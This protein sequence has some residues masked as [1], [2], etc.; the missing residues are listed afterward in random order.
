VG[1]LTGADE[2]FAHAELIA[3]KMGDEV[4]S[5]RARVV[6]V[7]WGQDLRAGRDWDAVH[8]AETA[9]DALQ[10]FAPA[11][12]DEGMGLAWSAIAGASWS[13][14]RADLAADAWTKAADHF[15]RAGDRRNE[16]E[17]LEWLAA[18]PTL[19]PTH[20]T[21]AMAEV[22][23]VLDRVR[24]SFEAETGVRDTGAWLLVMRGELDEARDIMEL[25]RRTLLDLGS[26]EYWAFE[27]QSLGWLEL[28]S[29]NAERSAEIFEEA[30]RTLEEMGSPASYIIAA[31]LAQALYR[32]DRMDEAAAHA[33]FATGGD[34]SGVVM[35]KGVLSRI[36]ARRGRFDEALAMQRE[37]IEM[38]E[39]SDFTNDRADARMDLAEVYELAGRI[40]DARTA[41]DDAIALFDEKGNLLQASNARTWLEA[42]G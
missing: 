34:L 7:T 11:G 15:R 17:V 2:R 29:G 19:G 5:A 42:L 13:R 18:A 6:R 25:R 26:R 21:Q 22:D 38:I 9:G 1:D 4:L 32:L 14:S 36:L 3:G 35:A 31:F 33:G 28:V 24:G 16:L 10:I 40:E 23:A 39:S 27:S 41:A 37:A 12:D 8:Q 30:R 20:V